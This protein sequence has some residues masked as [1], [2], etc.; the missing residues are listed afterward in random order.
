MS[1]VYRGEEEAEAVL[2]F[3]EQALYG[4]VKIG[5]SRYSLEEFQNLK[6]YKMQYS[7]EM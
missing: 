6:F 2:T 5:H 7:L 4:R 3:K 1:L